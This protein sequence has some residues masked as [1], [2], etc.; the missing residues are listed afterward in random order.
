M[1]WTQRENQEVYKLHMQKGT[2]VRLGPKLVSINC[3][4]GGLKTIYQ[5]GFPKP[6]WYMHAFAVYGVGN[7]F[8]I[9]DNATHSARKRIMS[10]TF[11][12]SFIMASQSARAAINETLF[13]RVLPLLYE[14]AL[15]D[16]AIEVV[17]FNYSYYLDTFVQ[18]QFGRS[19]RSN[20]IENEEERRMYLDGFFGISKFTFW[21]Y[22]FPHLSSTLRKLGIYLIPRWVDTGFQEVEDW[23]MAKCDKA[24]QLL[25]TEHDISEEEQ[26][27]VFRQLLKGVSTIDSKPRQYPRRLEVASDM[28]SLNSGAFETSGNTST[29]LFYEMCRHPEWQTKLR[30]ELLSLKMPL[31][32]TQGRIVEVTDIAQPGHVDELPIL[33]AVVMET[34]RLW[35]SVPGGQPRVVPRPC[36]LG[37]YENIP[38]GTVVQCYASVLH[39]TPEIFP[40]PHAW[41]PERWLN[42]K[43]E[44]LTLMNRWFWGFGSGGR[45]CIGKAFAINSIKYL[46]GGVYTNFTTTIHDHGDMTPIDNYLA[47]PKGHKLEVKF[48]LA[49]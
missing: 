43:P 2:A 23:N 11:S 20:L 28:F 1:R 44:Q 8:T 48:S 16:K 15:S 36:T 24:Q 10:H 22:Y 41:K 26:P 45:G 29:Y 42:T 17:E 38:A 40:E 30:Q 3:F 9:Q 6:K 25:A 31:K 18:W 4:D 39:K 49:G 37:G 7:L 12:K 21:Q 34:L 32:Y 35:P 19:L 27:V 5:G 13:Q 14:A 33:D 46:F 47:G